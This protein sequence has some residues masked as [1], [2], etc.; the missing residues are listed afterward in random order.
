MERAGPK[1]S[2]VQTTQPGHLFAMLT[3]T[4]AM[5]KDTMPPTMPVWTISTTLGIWCVADVGCRFW[6]AG[7]LPYWKLMPMQMPRT[8]NKA[9]IHTAS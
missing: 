7:E 2:E 8:A 4:K 5:T 1:M 6:N 9:S 3:Y